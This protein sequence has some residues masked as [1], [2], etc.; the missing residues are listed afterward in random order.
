[1]EAEIDRRQDWDKARE[2][3]GGE[4][5]EREGKREREDERRSSVFAREQEK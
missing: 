1:M 5:Y 2:R 3:E 4:V